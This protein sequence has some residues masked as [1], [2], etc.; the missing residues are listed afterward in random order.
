M[1]RRLSPFGKAIKRALLDKNMTQEELAKRVGTS[2]A[3]LGL[4]LFGNRTGMKY[5]PGIVAELGLDS[6][7]ENAQRAG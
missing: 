3:Y 7:W 1:K 6:K 2:P 4:I 5:R